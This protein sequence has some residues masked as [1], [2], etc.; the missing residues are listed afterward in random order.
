M[1]NEGVKRKISAILSADVVGYSRLMEADEESTVRTLESYRKTISGLIQQH[2]G[3]VVDSPGDNLLSEFGSVVDAVQCAVEIQHVIKAKNAVLPEIRRMDFRIGINLG[4]V[5]Q[6]GD[7]IYGDGVNIASR[8][9]GLAD[10]G[11]ISISSS[12]Y[13]QIESKLA[14]GYE[15]IGEHSVKNITKPVHVYRIPMDSRVV[16]DAG[17]KKTGLKRF[18]WAALILVG[19]IMGAGALAFWNHYLKPSPS[20]E[21]AVPE[22]AS[23]PVEKPSIAVLP[24]ENMSGNPDQEYFS[25]GITEEIISRLSKNSML[26]V[27]ARNSTFTYKGKPIKVQQV[28]QDL[29]VQHVLEGSVRR[30]GNRVRITA[31]LIDAINGGH[32]WSET[33]ERE[34]KDI[35]VVQAE[36]AQR[37]ATA[38]RVQYTEA[39]LSR[40]KHIP[41]DNLTAYDAFWLGYGHLH[42]YTRVDNAQALKYFQRAVELDPGYADAYGMIAYAY[43]ESFRLR[44]D[45]D[46]QL[47]ERAF[48]LS[49][50]ALSLD[51]TSIW[52][53]IAQYEIYML[54]N[55]YEFAL[56]KAEKVISLDPNNSAGYD[57]K[58]FALRRLGR[59]EEAIENLKKATYLDPH[60]GIYINNLAAL[61]KSSG[62]YKESIALLKKAV[63]DNPDSYMRY[64]NLAQCCIFS[65]NTQKDENP[66]ALEVALEMAENIL[67][68]DKNHPSG[69]SLFSTT[70]LSKKQYDLA[71]TE[72]K[73]AIATDPKFPLGYIM[74]GRIYGF[75]GR[76]DESIEIIKK[77]KQLGIQENRPLSEANFLYQLGNAYRLSGRQDEALSTYKKVFDHNPWH[78]QAFDAHLGMA[79]IYSELGREEEA[80]AEAEEVLKLSP[81][82]SVEI[83]GE[84]VPYRDPAMAER[85]M[86][87][88]RKAGLK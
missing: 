27:I 11:G 9:E 20:S 22:K 59:L 77:A 65:W 12:T 78:Y 76:A 17:I 51:S 49:K 87:A 6:E 2:H 42:R 41:T 63:A 10:A 24:F 69:Y 18:Q 52:A 4:D 80:H 14:L 58:G 8:I 53:H 29:G 44:W 13:E 39:E 83:Y 5:I 26:T 72:A 7:R 82:F 47:Q 37:I 60:S 71:I 36:I 31:Q 45:T 88:L 73:K 46:P 3:R 40:V 1:A 25:D 75:I 79:I 33:Y 86:A 54:R 74:L 66:Q 61:Y 68:L 21:V 23:A 16:R 34:M 30:S 62:L 67:V 43:I 57:A 70:Y 81:N 55:Q 35:F 38:L 85:D 32:L 15:D 19:L 84:R 48:D 28:A 50:K 56:S 64:W